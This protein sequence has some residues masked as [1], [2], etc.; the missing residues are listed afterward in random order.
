[1][2]LQIPTALLN[3]VEYLKMAK[4]EVSLNM[5]KRCKD[6]LKEKKDHILLRTLNKHDWLL[7]PIRLCAECLE[8][9]ASLAITHH[10]YYGGTMRQS[11]QVAKEED[12]GS[13]G[14]S[15]FDDTYFFTAPQNCRR[16]NLR[17]QRRPTMENCSV[18]N[19]AGL[20]FRLDLI[21]A[22]IT[23]RP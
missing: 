3:R 13:E 21:L 22:H 8:K 4:T 18:L 9:N 17:M 1:M 15:L 20:C 7:L 6:T 2:Q 23:W 10:R 14:N 5:C 19:S 11:G 12:A 16:S